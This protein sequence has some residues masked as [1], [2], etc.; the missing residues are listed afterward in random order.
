LHLAFGISA[1]VLQFSV[2]GQAITLVQQ[3]DEALVNQYESAVV[4]DFAA[5]VYLY[6]SKFYV[7][8]SAPQIVPVDA[9]LNN[10]AGAQNE[11][12][13]HYYGS[14]GYKLALSNDFEL[15][16]TLE[17]NYVTPAPPQ[18]DLGARV[19]YTKNFWLG[20][21]YR[22]GDAVYALVGYTYMNSMTFGF[23]YDYSIT[24][25]AK[26]ST[27]TT[28]FYIG[29]KFNKPKGPDHPMM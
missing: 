21:G 27:G 29:I 8:F 9:K 12:V 1:G 26:Y 14:A 22:T 18:L 2:D 5:G 3:N 10:F 19:I 13:T 6:S 16:P 23:S 20:A 24:D 17:A 4:P 25:I 15:N 28:E 11:L 7:G